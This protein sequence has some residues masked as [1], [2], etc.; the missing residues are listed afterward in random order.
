MGIRTFNTPSMKN[1]LLLTLVIL[2]CLSSASAQKAKAPAFS[3]C[4]KSG[5]C[6]MTWDEFLNCKKALTP[7]DKTQS[8]GNWVL[9]IQKAEH[10]DTV[11]IEFIT[12]G[13]M[14]SKSAL[15]AIAELHKKKKMGGTVLIDQVMVLQSGK[16][17]HK[18]PGMTIYLK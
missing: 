18:V 9:T 4:G 13:P 5:D 10:K 7:L 6:T 12:K 2:G 17:A 16:D 1:L 14:F 11:V 15:D 3:V 8:I